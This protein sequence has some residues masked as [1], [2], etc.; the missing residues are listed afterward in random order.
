M[1]SCRLCGYSVWGA[2]GLLLVLGPALAALLWDSLGLGPA[3]RY[4]LVTAAKV[5]VCVC[6]RACVCVCTLSHVQ[7]FVTPMDCSPPGLLCPW[8]SSGKSTGVGCHS[9]RQGISPTQGLNPCLLHWGQIL[10]HWAT[11]EAGWVCWTWLMSFSASP[12]CVASSLL[13]QPLTCYITSLRFYPF[14]HPAPDECPLDTT[15]CPLVI[16]GGP[17][18]GLC[19]PPQL[20]SHMGGREAWEW[21]W[22]FFCFLLTLWPWHLKLLRSSLLVQ[23]LMGPGSTPKKHSVGGMLKTDGIYV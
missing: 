20:F 16:T 11:R 1:T 22:N 4:W 13:T 12:V 10:Y 21:K 8:D 15:Q 2:A 6:A 23:N 18:G 14:L 7:L 3:R 5:C 17:K 19:A 9:P